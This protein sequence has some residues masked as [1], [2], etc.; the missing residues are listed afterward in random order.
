MAEISGGEYLRAADLD[1]RIA[2][3]R[4]HDAVRNS[5]KPLRV[6]SSNRRPMKR[7]ME[8]EY[9]C[10]GFVHGLPLGDLAHQAFAILAD[11]HDRRG[12]PRAFL[13]DDH[14]GLPA[15]HDG[16]DGVRRTRGQ[17]QSPSVASVAVLPLEV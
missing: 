13:I 7:L 14:G 5:A 9:V 1:P 2:L 3:V 16:N 15:F 10:S 11:G 6:T 8:K 4:P 17:F 12:R